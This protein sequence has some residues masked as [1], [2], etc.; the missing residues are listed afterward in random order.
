MAIIPAN[1]LLCFV[2]NRISSDLNNDKPNGSIISYQFLF[3]SSDSFYLNIVGV[4]C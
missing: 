3:L 1:V 4:E 2:S